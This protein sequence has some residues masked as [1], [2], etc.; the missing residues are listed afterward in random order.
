MIQIYYFMVY[1][2]FIILIIMYN[3]LKI[4]QIKNQ[5]LFAI[6]NL[7]ISNI[8]QFHKIKKK[9]LFTCKIYYTT[10]LLPVVYDFNL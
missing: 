2:Y 6:L 1:L 5:F 9:F 3:V 4:K 7:N 8:L 10:Y